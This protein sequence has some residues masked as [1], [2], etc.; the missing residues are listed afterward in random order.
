[1]LFTTTCCGENWKATTMT[2]EKKGMNEKSIL[3]IS[4][5]HWDSVKLGFLPSVCFFL[6]SSSSFQYCVS[7]NR[8]RCLRYQLIIFICCTSA[9][10]LVN[11]VQRNIKSYVRRWLFL[12]RN[13]D[14]AFVRLCMKGDAT[15]T[16]IETRSVF[17]FIAKCSDC[18]LL[19][20]VNWYWGMQND[21]LMMEMIS[22]VG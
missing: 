1:M 19:S 16:C 3:L 9:L 17:K 20:Y 8:R 7:H 11:Y 15:P 14:K 12:I 2:T 10:C 21:V 18:Q 6:S 22:L 4:S 5:F 13:I